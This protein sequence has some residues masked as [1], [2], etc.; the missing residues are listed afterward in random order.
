MR[1]KNR[2][3]DKT[4]AD[5]PEA[6][7]QPSADGVRPGRPD[8]QHTIRRI[9]LLVLLAALVPGLVVQALLHL[10]RFKGEQAREMQAH[11]DVSRAVAVAFRASI[12]D[13]AQEANSIGLAISRLAVKNKKA[14]SR[15]LSDA[16]QRYPLAAELA[17]LSPEGRVIASSDGGAIGEDRH[18]EEY[19]SQL[20]RERPRV[21]GSVQPNRKTGAAIFTL[22]QVLEDEEGRIIGALTITIDAERF[23]DTRLKIHRTPDAGFI[24]IRT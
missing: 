14:A 12:E 19:F 9:L 7:S 17:W 15:F 20:G 1:E 10:N 5:I 18:T 21:L 8:H 11:I 4:I 2:A 6:Q 24:T 16:L 23:A 13:V 3:K 22:A